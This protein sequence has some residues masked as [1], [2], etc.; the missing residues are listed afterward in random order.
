MGLDDNNR[1]SRPAALTEFFNENPMLNS[2]SRFGHLYWLISHLYRKIVK[3]SIIKGD[4]KCIFQMCEKND[5]LTLTTLLLYAPEQ[6]ECS[7]TILLNFN[8]AHRNIG[9][10]K[11]HVE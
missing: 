5:W 11:A 8:V 4:I 7:N 1:S 2:L 10:K 6:F 9:E 3:K